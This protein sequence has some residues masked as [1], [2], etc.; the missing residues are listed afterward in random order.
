MVI[1]CPRCNRPA[2]IV[3]PSGMCSVCEINRDRAKGR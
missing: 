1:Y 3:Y 2:V